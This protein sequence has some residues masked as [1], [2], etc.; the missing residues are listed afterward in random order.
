MKESETTKILLENQRQY[1]EAQNKNIEVLTQMKDSLVSL[2]D[3]NV[4]HLTK[5]DARYDTI[6]QLGVAVEARSK[7]MNLVFM[8]LIAAV[9]ILAGAEKALTI[10]KI[11]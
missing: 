10:L 7:V 4:L 3:T 11:L 1:L 2:N 9:I 6:K 5:E 8:L